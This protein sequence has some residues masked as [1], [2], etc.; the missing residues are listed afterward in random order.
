MYNN[1]IPIR[2]QEAQFT[3]S[4]YQYKALMKDCAQI[5]IIKKGLDWYTHEVL[6]LLYQC[7]NI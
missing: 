4:I 5:V 3:I 6:K 2:E 7:S 1:L